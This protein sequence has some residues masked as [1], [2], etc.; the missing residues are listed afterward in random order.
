MIDLTNRIALVTGASRG[1]GHAIVEA[2]AKQG[3]SVVAA[4]RG[5]NAVPT[6]ASAVPVPSQQ[7]GAVQVKN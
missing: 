5:D 4:S 7:P 1:I 3:A 6:Q 2:L